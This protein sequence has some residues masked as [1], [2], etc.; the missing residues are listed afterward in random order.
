LRSFAAKN[1]QTVEN[2]REN[3]LPLASGKIQRGQ[4]K[5]VSR[6]RDFRVGMDPIDDDHIAHLL[7]L[8]RYERP[9]PDY[10]EN[11]LR[12]FRRRQRDKLVRQPVWRI[13]F[14]RVEGFAF[15]FNIRSLASAGIA[16]VIACAAVISIKL[17]QQPDATEVAVQGS[18][19]PSTPPTTERELDF[20]PPVLNATFDMQP[21]LFPG[22]RRVPVQPIHSLRSDEFVPLNLEWESLDDQSQPEK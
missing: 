1:S 20:A 15:W 7:R 6:A 2:D 4:M 13:C 10:F 3:F 16:A 5:F 8:K 17:Y 9:P 19:V 12:E 22:S 21:T 18:P 11:F 14:E